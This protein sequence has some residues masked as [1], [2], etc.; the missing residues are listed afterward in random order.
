MASTNG[1]AQQSNQK[2]SEF[3]VLTEA[4]NRLLLAKK[5]GMS[6]GGE[7]DLYS[8]L[9]YPSYVSA[10]DM[11]FRW[12]RQD[13]AR[14]I[15]DRPVK[16]TWQGEINIT[17]SSEEDETALE[18]AY[19]ELDKK[20]KLISKFTRLDR[21]SQLGRYSVLFLG[22]DDSAPDT[23]ALP[24]SPG[25]RELRYVRPV[26]EKNAEI[27]TWE[28]DPTNERYG[29]PRLYHIKLE[30]PG[31]KDSITSLTV[32]HS[33]VIHL[34]Q[35]LLEDD[36]EGHPVTESVF[37]RLM[38]IE[39]LVGGSAE[40]FWRGARP[41]YAAKAQEGYK[42]GE[43]VKKDF[44]EQVKEYENDLRRILMSEGVDIESLAQQIADPKG[45]LEIQLQMIS[46][47]T[48]IPMRILL[49]S[50]RGELASSQDATAWKEF[51]QARRDEMAA[52]RI[53]RPF[54]DRLISV[55]A[56]PPIK[57]DDEGYD[58]SWPD[59]F[60]MNDGDKA[61]IGTKMTQA[62]KQYT[63]SGAEMSVPFE[64]FL[65]YFLK[66]DE[67]DVQHILKLRDGQ[68][69]DMARE[70]DQLALDAADDEVTEADETET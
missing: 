44:Q 8:T 26:S 57:E 63:E 2:Q 56:L 7:R 47:V 22:F 53:I 46:A 15:V 4:V 49:G 51:I 19:K 59:L 9:G 40:M 69:A 70:E 28:N 16:A 65:T 6:H 67:Q 35:D 33:R 13:I 14:A 34:A 43:A 5:L 21:L 1:T 24:I 30:K 61:D 45:H 58:V 36:I 52:P 29:Q 10:N 48:Q 3:Q 23:W 55:G 12:K 54:V 68:L 66:M 41:G 27:S 37:N 50:E 38:D 39:K 18:K 62:L 32:H 11:I 17:E 60:S 64:A 20:L 42:I 31:Q 25:K